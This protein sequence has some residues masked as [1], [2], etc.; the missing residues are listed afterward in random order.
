MKKQTPTDPDIAHEYDFSG[1]LR[2]KY[3]RQYAGGT[4]VVL[5]EPDVSEVF[6]D[7]TAVNKALRA[8][9]GIVKDHASPIP[10][11]KK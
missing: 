3:A 2:G 6:P 8:L 9:A 7:S 10:A 4:N 11:P 5:L 1:A